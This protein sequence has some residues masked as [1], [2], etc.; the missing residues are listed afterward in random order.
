MLTFRR[1]RRSR[2]NARSREVR[3][4]EDCPATISDALVT[5]TGA[6]A[7]DAVV[8]MLADPAPRAAKR[9]LA[10][11]GLIPAAPPVFTPCARGPLAG[12]LLA[13]PALTATGLAETAHEIYGEYA[14]GFYSLDTMLYE[15]VFRAL[16]GEA[17]A[18]GAARIDPVAPGR[19]L[20]LGRA[21]QVKTIRRKIRLLADAGKAGDWT[22]AMARRHVEARPEPAAVLYVD[23]HVR[24]FQGTGRIAKTHAPRLKL[25][26]PATVET[27][28]SDAAGNPLLVVMA[29]PAA[30]LAAELRPLIP[31]LR[32]T[33]GDH[34]RVLVGFD[35]GGWSPTLFADLDAAWFDTLT[36]RKGATADIDEQAFATHS[37]TD[38][39]GRAHT[40]RLADSVIGLHIAGGPRKGE[41]FAMRQISLFESTRTRQMHI[42]TT[43]ADLPTAEIRYRMGSAGARRTTTATPVS[44]SI[45]TPRLGVPPARGGTSAPARTTRPGWCPT[46]PRNPPT[47]RSKRPGVHCIRPKPPVTVNCWRHRRRRR[48][49]HRGHQR[50]DRHDQHRRARRRSHPRRGTGL[51]G[52]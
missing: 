29:E 28:V 33:V 21:P 13:V 19:V 15:G 43:R 18:E 52:V 12:L 36:W 31:E 9:A 35:R 40:W 46:R 25:P 14:T 41:V 42:L 47:C 34:R 27:R 44:I 30:S 16:L 6:G 5:D 26:A 8:P 4:E 37:H 10:R 22:A 45:S 1:N 3:A 50:D 2:S 39:H 51:G 20:G 11:F 32:A 24:T 23:G 49:H 17:R 48:G 7:A 38:E